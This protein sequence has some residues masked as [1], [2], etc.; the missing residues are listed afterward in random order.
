MTV[1]PPEIYPAGAELTAQGA[2]AQYVYLIEDGAVKLVHIF[3][4]GREIILDLQMPGEVV[5]AASVMLSHPSLE[6]AIT[7]SRCRLVRWPAGQFVA[8]AGRNK[9]FSS[10]VNLMLAREAQKMRARMMMLAHGRARE[11]LMVFLNNYGVLVS[12]LSDAGPQRGFVL[13]VM[14]GELAQLLAVTPFHL[15]RVWRA[16][17]R[18]GLVRR[19][20]GRIEVN[21]TGNTGVIRAQGASV[22]SSVPT[23]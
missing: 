6:T 20:R 1:P 10:V 14:Q 17:E 18:D 8:E 11:R 4:D 15:S 7:I 2:T 9:A 12:S 21:L 16:L 23:D 13:P 5:A 19:L 22:P 3:P